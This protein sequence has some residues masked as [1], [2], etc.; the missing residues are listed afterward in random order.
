M[1][2]GQEHA[3]AATNR[4]REPFADG[5]AGV[6]DELRIHRH[7]SGRR[8]AFGLEARC[9]PDEI[10]DLVGVEALEA[11][12]P[13]LLVRVALVEEPDV[14]QDVVEGMA[15]L[16][17]GD[18]PRQQ[19]LDQL[20]ARVRPRRPAIVERREAGGVRSDNVH[21]HHRTRGRADARRRGLSGTPRFGRGRHRGVVGVRRAR[22][23]AFRA[24]RSSGGDRGT[25]ARPAR[26]ARR[27]DRLGRRLGPAG[28]L[29]RHGARGSHRA[30][31]SRI[32]GVRTMRRPGQ[33]RRHPR[34]RSVR[35][36]RHRLPGPRDRREPAGRRARDEAVPPDD[37]GA[38][39]RA[40]R[41]HRLARGPVR[42]AGRGRLRCDQARRGRVQRGPVPRARARRASW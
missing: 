1:T 39:T 30:P 40:H 2:R 34:R 20:L 22:G 19:A 41:E 9:P 3:L 36:R 31:R 21:R 17:T 42:D 23:P 5:R 7:R 37:A 12:H 33:Q 38:S 28:P 32:R 29:R 13:E 4:V 25:P 14:A 15:D 10:E 16:E 27:A 8:R 18:G 11:G 24:G 26:G 6:Q 35:D